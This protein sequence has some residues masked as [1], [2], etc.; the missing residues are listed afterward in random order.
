MGGNPVLS[1]PQGKA[2]ETLK[3]IANVASSQAALEILNDEG[4][5]LYSQFQ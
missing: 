2:L 4:K 5:T 1:N 3:R